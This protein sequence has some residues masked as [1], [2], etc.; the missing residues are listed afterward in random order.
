VDLL[1]PARQLRISAPPVKK[2]CIGAEG[3]QNLPRDLALHSQKAQENAEP[4]GRLA[5]SGRSQTPSNR[6]LAVCAG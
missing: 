2:S 6:P 5:R 1:L 4:L 3:F